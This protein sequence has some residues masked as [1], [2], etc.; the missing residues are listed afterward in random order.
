M[1][2]TWIVQTMRKMKCKLV[3]DAIPDFNKIC[4]TFMDILKPDSIRKKKSG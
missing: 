4:G 1:K 3:R 2:L